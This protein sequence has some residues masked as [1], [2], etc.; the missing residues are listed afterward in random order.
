MIAVYIALIIAAMLIAIVWL[1][2][3]V[4]VDLDFHWSITIARAVP[5]ASRLPSNNKETSN[6]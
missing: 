2:R 4:T 6:A 1:V 5:Q 3:D